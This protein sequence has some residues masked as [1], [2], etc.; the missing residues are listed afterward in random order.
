MHFELETASGET[1][2]ADGITVL[3][4]CNYEKWQRQVV[5]TGIDKRLHTL[6]IGVELLTP[7]IDHFGML[8]T[9]W[10]RYR[11]HIPSSLPIHPFRMYEDFQIHQSCFE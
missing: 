2:T 9:G 10:Y 4:A 6:C 11:L 8:R 1:L 5:V 7:T 3:L